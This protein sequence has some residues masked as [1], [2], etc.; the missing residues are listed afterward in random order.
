ME[1]QRVYKYKLDFYYVSLIVYMLFL[2]VYILINGFLF[3]RQFKDLYSDPIVYVSLIFIIFFLILLIINVIRAREIVFE[4][5]KILIRNRFG[6]REI[7]FSEIENLKFS[8]VRRKRINGIRKSE[9]SRVKIYLT[10]RKRPLR[11]RV[12]VFWDE[13]KLL[14]EFRHL[15]KLIYT[16]KTNEGR[17]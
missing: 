2:L 7:M 11:I 13:K 5:T 10:G 16:T 14:N 12:N 8:K 9:I 4:E 3:D 1:T 17:T 6:Q 15:V